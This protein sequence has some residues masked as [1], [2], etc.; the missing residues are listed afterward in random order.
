M[1]TAIFRS[2]LCAGLMVVGLTSLADADTTSALQAFRAGD[3]ATAKQ[4]F[5]AAAEAGDPAAG[6]WLGHMY[7]E[8]I[9]VAKDEA[10]A[11]NWMSK[12]A[13]GDEVAAMRGL[14]VMY[15]NGDGVLQDYALAKEWLERAAFDNDAAAQRALGTIY[16]NGLGVPKNNSRAYVWFDFAARGGDAQAVEKR[17]ALA[18]TLT[19]QELDDA[20]AFSETVKSEI[21]SIQPD[22]H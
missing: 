7:A 16:A 2:I 3:Y 12:S 18:K 19:P 21:L 14:G 15:L 8:G 9:G 20:Q 5:E 11:A 13:A 22:A 17:D 6:Y 1:A 4:G 10:V